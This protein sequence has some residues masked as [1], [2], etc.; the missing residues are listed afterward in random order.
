MR[1]IVDNEE[2]KRQVEVTLRFLRCTSS[3]SPPAIRGGVQFGVFRDT[4]EKLLTLWKTPEKIQVE[5]N[6][7]I[8]S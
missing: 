7:E 1:I 8:Q 5:E 2:E 3:H 4:Q 6:N